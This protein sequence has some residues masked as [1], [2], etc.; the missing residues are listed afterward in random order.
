[1]KY[2]IIL[3]ILIAIYYQIYKR[4]PE[5]F[6]NQN[7]LYF[8]S[9]VSGYIVLYYL[10]TFQK[11]FVYNIMKSV[12]NADEQPLYDKNSIVF[13]QNQMD[14]L[15]YNLAMRQGW[16]CLHCQNPILQQDI[17][18]YKLHYIKPLQFGGENNINNLGIKCDAC[19][20]FSPY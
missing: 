19:S 3:C 16:R 10:M 7:H 14:G 1:M 4:C 2:I 20:S 15:K 17:Y 12:K 18:N 5:H 11:P 9:F 6:T 13:K 8:G